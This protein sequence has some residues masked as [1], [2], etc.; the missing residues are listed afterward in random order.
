MDRRG[1]P[2][3]DQYEL[4]SLCIQE[5]CDLNSSKPT[6]TT[7]YELDSSFDKDYPGKNLA[8]VKHVWVKGI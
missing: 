4:D 2:L 6:K 5:G 3:S 8:N 1:T 7:Q